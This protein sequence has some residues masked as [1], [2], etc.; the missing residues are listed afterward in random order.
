MP[1]SN[2]TLIAWNIAGVEAQAGHATEI[3]PA[4][5]MLG[6]CK[7][8]DVNWEDIADRLFQGDAGFRTEMENDLRLLCH[9]FKRVQIQPTQFR[10]RLRALLKKEGPLPPSQSTM[11]RSSDCRLLFE[12]AEHLAERH[13]GKAQPVRAHHLLVA[14]LEL[15]NSSWASLY[16]EFGLHEVL[17]KARETGLLSEQPGGPEPSPSQSTVGTADAAPSK[18]PRKAT[19]FSYL[20]HFGRDLTALAKD[21]KLEPL[22]GRRHEMRELIRVLLKKRKNNPILVGDPGVGKTCLVEGLASWLIGPDVVSALQDRRIVEVSMAALVAGTKHRG[23]FEERIQGII[24]EAARSKNVIIFIDEIHMALGAGSG[25]GGAMD[26]ANILKPALARGDFPCIGATTVKEYRKYIEKDAALERR[27]QMVQIDEPTPG[28]T[29]EILQGLR[30]KFETHHGLTISQDAI[31]AAVSF[32]V[33]YLQDFRLP[34]KAID[35]I[36]QACASIRLIALGMGSAG[37]LPVT[38]IGKA[39]VA[40]VIAE[41]CGLPVQQ[42]TR[43]EGQRLLLMEQALGRRVIGQTEAVAAVSQAIR[44]GRAGLAD[45]RK[46]HG[47][48]LFVGPTGTGKT[49]LAKALAEFLF[50]SESALVRIDMSEYMEKHSLSRL[51]GAPPGYIGHDEEGQLTG[52]L[53]RKP[54]SVVLLDEI[55]KAH[56]DIL[57]VFLQLFDDGRLTDSHGKTADARQAIFIMTS[58]LTT[59][60][61]GLKPVGFS[62]GRGKSLPG[63]SSDELTDTLQQWFRPEFL[64]RLTKVVAFKQLSQQDLHEIARKMLHALIERTGEQGVA[65]EI[66]EDAIVH[67][68]KT[69]YDPEYGARPLARTIDT[70]VARPLA[71]LLIGGEIKGKEVVRV[72]VVKDQIAVRKVEFAPETKW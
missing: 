52:S 64:N 35:L 9:L 59:G 4:H 37:Q 36:D 22:I 24:A 13:D 20:E 56:P 17:S 60:T 68:S 38:E 30:G 66:S 69:A 42:L 62:A 47:V 39:E 63:G 57:N 5:V 40:A 2:S 6:L 14:I 27:F 16:Q 21:H 26:A 44:T 49:E 3:E 72:S 34:D 50:G 65:L 70:L 7:V 67:L 29:T 33:R 8:C 53:R 55:E 51:I 25:D 32:S 46:P 12:H 61:A 54:Y 11:H 1:Y 48:F 43:E 19:P 71:T 41:R 10:R 18:R 28:E 23:D 31:D 58:N 15:E 45:P